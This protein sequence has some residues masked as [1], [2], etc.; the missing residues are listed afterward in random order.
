METNMEN[1]MADL[2]EA[3]EGSMGPVQYDLDYKDKK[4]E[5]TL[6]AGSQFA[7][8]EMKV[9]LNAEEVIRAIAKATPGTWDDALAEIVISKL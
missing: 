3:V 2:P 9:Y 1:K 5:L 6:K 7:H 8:V 4:V